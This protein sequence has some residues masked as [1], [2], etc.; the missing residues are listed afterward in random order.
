MTFS[1]WDDG[2]TINRMPKPR[3]GFSCG[4]INKSDGDVEVVLAGGAY[5]GPS[6]VGNLS[7]TIDIFSYNNNDWRTV[8]KVSFTLA[9]I[10]SDRQEVGHVRRTNF[11]LD[12]G[13]TWHVHPNVLILSPR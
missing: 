9:D 8:G 13:Q 6:E 10:M 1:A 7:E 11:D 2:W 5:H 3:K 4:V 12:G